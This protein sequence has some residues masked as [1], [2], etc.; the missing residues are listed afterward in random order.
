MAEQALIDALRFAREGQRLVGELDLAAMPRLHDSV[1]EATGRVHYVLS[2]LTDRSGD[3]VIEVNVRGTIPLLCQRCLERMDYALDR[4]TRLALVAE[5][6]RLPDVAEEAP[7][8]EAIAAEDVSN[9]ADLIEQE[10]LLG[11]PLAPMHAQTCIAARIADDA[12]IESPF[13]ALR[14]L[15]QKQR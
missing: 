6:A 2:G 15:K 1:V 8:T 14:T 10:V 7:D 4:T 12:R 9:V 3:P 5:V 13:A 11:L